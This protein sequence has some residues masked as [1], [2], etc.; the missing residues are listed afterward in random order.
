MPGER[1]SLQINFR[2]FLTRGKIGRTREE[3]LVIFDLQHEE[4]YKSIEKEIKKLEKKYEIQ[5]DY[6]LNIVLPNFYPF[7]END[8]YDQKLNELLI[9]FFENIQ[10]Y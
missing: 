2:I 8:F 6:M 4:E 5:W 1:K 9:G 7:L 3:K 10:E